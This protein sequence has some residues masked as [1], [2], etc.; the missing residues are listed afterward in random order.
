[1]SPTPPSAD[2]TR[3]LPIAP[4]AGPSRR[5][6]ALADDAR[7]VDRDTRPVYCVWELTL[8]CDLACRHCGSRAGRARPDELS[9]AEALDVV[10]QL[11]E[12]GVL[13]VTLI[14]GEA[15]LRD[16][17]TLIARAI[18]DRG[19]M[20]SVTT[21][22]RGLDRDRALA[23]RDAGVQ[24]A[25]VSVDG[26][27]KTHDALRGVQGSFASAMKAIENLHEVG[28]RVSSNTQIC[29]PNVRE[30]PEVFEVLAGSGIHAWQMQLTVAMGRAADDPGVLLE[31][32]QMLEVMPMLARVKRR[33]MELDVVVWPAA[34][35][36]YFGPDEALL[37]GGVVRTKHSSCG[38]GRVSLGLEANGDVKGCP[39]LPTSEYVGGNVRDASLR[40]IWE[41]AT[42]LRFTR[43]R[44]VDDLRGFCRTCYYAEACMGGCT[45]T[46]HVLLGRPGDNPFCHHRAIELLKQGKRERL[47]QR[48]P[49]GGAPFDHGVFEIVRE[50]WPLDELARANRIVE[51][52]NG[53]LK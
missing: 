37:R 42:P 44:T 51:T 24:G 31:P 50:D 7:A 49:A 32:Y 23:A 16:D 10:A 48:A 6:L 15:Y 11:A 14:G 8:Q 20:C 13:E 36:G 17:W 1:M 52:G 12:L 19:M 27:E 25:S 34:N 4:L 28:I 47:V 21:G 35:I 43:D 22:G 26:L 9:T 5:R 29:R 38:A 53:W 41:R 40:D 2:A 30:I 45:W 39:S 46:A 18:R 33:A 3:R